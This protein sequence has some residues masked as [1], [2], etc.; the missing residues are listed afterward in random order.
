MSNR[1][2]DTIM[3]HFTD[4]RHFGTLD[5]P[6]GTGVSG[7]PGR[8]PYLVFQI[9]LR[10]G[11]VTEAA[12]QCHNCGVTVACGSMLTEMVE[13]KSVAECRTISSGDLAQA[14]DGLPVDKQ[15][16]AEFAL[17]AL[18]MALDEASR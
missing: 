7:V 9:E 8:G 17:Q 12:F 2:S 10:D 3:D 4:P 1:Y 18:A 6:S 5:E 15:H 14:L 16:V 13:S 11:V